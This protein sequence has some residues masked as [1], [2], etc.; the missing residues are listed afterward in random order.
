M[1]NNNKG[2]H[3][4]VKIIGTVIVIAFLIFMS[5]A[6]LG[7]YWPDIRDY[8]YKLES[9]RLQKEI[10]A[11]KK[12]VEDLEKADTFGGKTPEETFDMF[13]EALKKNDAE[14]ASKY[15]DVR[16][17]EEALKSLK[18]EITEKGSLEM[19]LAYYIDVRG[20]DKKCNDELD[21]CTFRFEYKTKKEEIIKDVFGSNITFPEGDT[22]NESVDFG[23]NRQTQ[24]WKISEI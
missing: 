23:L 13:L 21:G 5:V 22:I 9:E 19:S 1:E 4:A 18:D 6:A 16:V 12:R 7:Y 24:N 17:Q 11:E 15:Y 20:G 2:T 3:F 14:L 8:R 10:D